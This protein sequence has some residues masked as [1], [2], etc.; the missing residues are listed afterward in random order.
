MG[1]LTR[2]EVGDR[3]GHLLDDLGRRGAVVVR[4]RDCS[5]ARLHGVGL[6]HTHRFRRELGCLNGRSHDVPVVRQHD[7]LGS[8]C[9]LHRIGD[10]LRGRIGRLSAGN[11]DDFAERASEQAPVARAGRHRHDRRDEVGNPL[12]D[13]F[14]HVGDIDGR[15][16]HGAEA[17]RCSDRPLR[18]VRMHMDAQ[19]RAVTD[20]VKGVADLPELLR[21]HLTVEIHPFEDEIRAVLELGKLVVELGVRLS[22]VDRCNFGNID[23]R[24]REIEAPDK[25]DQPDPAGVDDPGLSELGEHVGCAPHCVLA[26][27]DDPK[28]Q[29]VLWQRDHLGPLGLLGHLP[30]HRQHRP[31]DGPL[32]RPVGL[33][34]RR[35]EGTREQHRVDLV[36]LTEHL[37][38]PPHD[39]TEDHSRVATGPH[40]SRSRQIL[41]D[42]LVPGRLRALQRIDDRTHGERQVGARVAV[43]YRVHV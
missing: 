43:G 22:L 8:V 4:E 24:H 18:L 23:T 11:D 2:P 26:A 25:L 40:Q 41:R 7:H 36:L 21:E 10:L 9:C 38:E 29:L 30:D 28:Q 16:D 42:G 12:A 15:L 19:H 33:V 37:G 1:Q 5:E 39:L 32:D 6:E 14:V 3:L 31:L 27:L 34:A 20:D 35:P 13:L 17:A